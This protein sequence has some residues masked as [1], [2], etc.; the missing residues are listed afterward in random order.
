MRP[1]RVDPRRQLERHVVA[2]D[3][4]RPV[5]NPLTSSNACRPTVLGP[6]DNRSSPTFASTRFSPFNGT[7]SA[8]VPMAASLANPRSHAVRAR[9]LTE[10]LHQLERHADAGQIL[11][12]IG[13]VGTARV[14]HGERRRKRRVRLVMVGDDE[15]DTQLT[16]PRRPRSRSEMPQST[17]TMTRTP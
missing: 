1:A 9:P 7:A 5:V 8:T 12:R 17:D 15:I 2:D 6:S 16:R 3:S 10:R 11:V 14:E 13:A 4:G